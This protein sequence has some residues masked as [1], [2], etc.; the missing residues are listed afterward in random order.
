[1]NSLSIRT[2]GLTVIAS[3][4]AA[5]AACSDG[6]QDAGTQEVALVNVTP[7]GGSMSV[8]PNTWIEIEFD[9]RMGNGMEQFCAVH[10]GELD[11][12]EVAGRW[13]WSPD[14]HVLTFTPDQPLGTSMQHT[15]HV[16]GGITDADGHHM[17]FDQHG[18]DMGG[19]W[20]DEDMLGQHGGMGG[21]PHMGDG[22]QHHNG[23]YGMAFPFHTAASSAQKGLLLHV[24][25]QGG[26]TN[27]DPGARIEMEFDHAM[28][29]GVEALCAVHLG[30]L[31]GEEVPG[32]W[33]WS[34]DHHVLT[35]TPHDPLQLDSEHTLHVGGGI[36][37]VD[38][39]HMDFDQHAFDMGGH[40]VDED[41]LS[42][43]GG[44]M[45]GHSHMGEG[46]QH[47]NGTYGMAFAFRTAP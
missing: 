47:E 13:E 7:R 20:V 45:G 10:M 12:G 2:L 4:F 38:G 43:H 21:H 32:A 46:W 22:W 11:G 14:R 39:H 30:G 44:M 9:S 6:T 18:V 40:W 19:H 26:S 31:N 24:S 41:M 3:L 36:T 25:P 37:D 35:F 34:E 16:G 27:V 23:F 28:A 15:L 42:H 33:E 8:N 5:S 29:D 1:M 17:D